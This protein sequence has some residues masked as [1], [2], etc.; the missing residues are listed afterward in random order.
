MK[1]RDMVRRKESSIDVVYPVG[2]LDELELGRGR[3]GEVSS[4]GRSRDLE[5]KSQNLVEYSF[6]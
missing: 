5:L 2:W 1:M 6:V 3:K 4:A